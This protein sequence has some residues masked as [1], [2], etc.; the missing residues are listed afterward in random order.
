[1]LLFLRAEKGEQGHTK[2]DISESGGPEGEQVERLVAVCIHIGRVPVVV[3]F[4]DG[5]DPHITQR[6]IIY[7]PSDEVF[8]S[9]KLASLL[10]I[11]A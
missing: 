6:K 5:V 3:G 1:M 11:L 7:M 10:Q 9:F 8:L 2:Q 4:I